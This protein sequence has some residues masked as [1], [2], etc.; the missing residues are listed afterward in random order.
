MSAAVGEDRALVTADSD[1]AAMLT[2]GSH[3]GAFCCLARSA[4]HLRPPRQAALLKATGMGCAT[5]LKVAPSPTSLA[6]KYWSE[7]RRFPQSQSALRLAAGQRR[8][9]QVIGSGVLSGD[10]LVE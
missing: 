10:Y 2:L 3:R 6:A 5:S 7:G 9:F 8:R 1:F 4:D